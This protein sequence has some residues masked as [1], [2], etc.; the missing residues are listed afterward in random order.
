VA[1][2]EPLY[3]RTLW[4]SVIFNH[5]KQVKRVAALKNKSADK[6]NQATKSDEFL[7]TKIF[8]N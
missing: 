1:Q 8:N 3:V 6:Y 4:N 7:F 5:N 2:I